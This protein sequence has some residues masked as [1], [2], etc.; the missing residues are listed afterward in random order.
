VSLS[1]C[2]TLLSVCCPSSPSPPLS[3]SSPAP[4]PPTIDLTQNATGGGTAEAPTTATTPSS[5]APTMT[6]P[7][8]YYAA[9]TG[10]SSSSVGRIIPV[11]GSL[12]GIEDTTIF[13]PVTVIA[14][15]TLQVQN[16]QVCA[17][18]LSSGDQTCNQIILNPEQTSFTPVDV[19]LASPT[20]TVTPEGETTTTGTTTPTQEPSTTTEGTTTDTTGTEGG[21]A[22]PPTTTEEPTTTEGGEGGG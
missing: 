13:V 6:T 20:P 7:S 1:C 16:A 22:A 3:P 18:L 2:S 11:S 19:D 14:P 21:A 9:E 15:I 17:Q 10:I 5:Y 4:A 12:I 8:L